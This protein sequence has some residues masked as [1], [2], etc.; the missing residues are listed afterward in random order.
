MFDI[1]MTLSILFALAVL[2]SMVC[3]TSF[4]TKVILFQGEYLIESGGVVYSGA[5]WRNHKNLTN[6]WK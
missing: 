1:F 5:P 3:P 2:K 4:R 6:V